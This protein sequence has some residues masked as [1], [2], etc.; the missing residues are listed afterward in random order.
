LHFEY[1]ELGGIDTG[2][3]NLSIPKERVEAIFR[4]D[5]DA[6]RAVLRQAGMA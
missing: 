4:R 6:A 1:P 5:L 2:K 3:K